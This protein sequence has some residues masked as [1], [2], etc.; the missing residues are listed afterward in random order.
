M[1]WLSDVFKFEGS[2]MSD[3]WG[4]IKQDPERLLVGAIDPASTSVW[5]KVLGKDWDPLVDQMGGATSERYASAES[6]GIDTTAGKG[7]HNI[8]RTVAG[9]FAGGYGANQLGFGAGG[10]T[11]PGGGYVPTSADKAGMFGNAGYGEGMT[12]AE[13]SAFDSGLGFD[14]AGWGSKLQKFG[15]LTQQAAGPQ[16]ERPQLPQIDTSGQQALIQQMIQQLAQR[17]G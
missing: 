14:Y 13:T 11:S 10:G 6:K 1:G 5:N 7:M 8:A 17:R 9:F 4:D 15:N 12:G 3:L 16:R 2:H